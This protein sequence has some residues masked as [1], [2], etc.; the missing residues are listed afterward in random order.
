M[1]AVESLGT[2]EPHPLGVSTGPGWK[3][4]LCFEFFFYIKNQNDLAFHPGPVQPPVV[5][6][7]LVE[8]KPHDP[9]ILGSSPIQ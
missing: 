8:H 2:G 4:P 9:K 3:W 7:P 5:K 6:A 1:F